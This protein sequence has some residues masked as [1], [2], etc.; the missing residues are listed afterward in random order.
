MEQFDTYAIFLQDGKPV[1]QNNKICLQNINDGSLQFCNYD[2][3]LQDFVKN[4]VTDTVPTCSSQQEATESK[5]DKYWS[6]NATLLLINLRKKFD[7]FFKSTTMKNDR[8]WRMVAAEIQKNDFD[9]SATQCRDKWQY[10]KKRYVKKADNMGDRGTGEERIKFEFFE[11]M[12]EVLEKKHNVHPIGTAS[13]IKGLNSSS[14]TENNVADV[15]EDVEDTNEKQLKKRKKKEDGVVQF[16][17]EVKKST[18]TREVSR[19]IRHKEIMASRNRAIEVFAEK[20]D[21][22]IERIGK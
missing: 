15:L 18:E 19:E 13:S 11:E 8:V 17:R 16:M 5:S 3:S 14:C 21:S 6:R 1:I 9:V 20:M 22:L 7:S 12:H 2:E 10:L 4:T